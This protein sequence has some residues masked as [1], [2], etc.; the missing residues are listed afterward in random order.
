VVWRRNRIQEQTDIARRAGIGKTM[1]GRSVPASGSGRGARPFASRAVNA[2]R[3]WRQEYYY[4][5][6]E[7]LGELCRSS[8]GDLV[9]QTLTAQAPTCDERYGG[10]DRSRLR[11]NFQIV[12]PD[13]FASVR[14]GPALRISLQGLACC[15]VFGVA[16]K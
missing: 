16:E 13:G 14:R 9:V 7:A 15:P 2:S 6:M 10:D 8:G 12:D 11:I 4:P 1:L 3:P 5:M